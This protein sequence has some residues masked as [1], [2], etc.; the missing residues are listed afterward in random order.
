MLTETASWSGSVTPTAN[1]T[2]I[3]YTDVG[4]N[5]Y[6]MTFILIHNF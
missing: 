4:T 5:E 1:S 2:D 3:H 6:N